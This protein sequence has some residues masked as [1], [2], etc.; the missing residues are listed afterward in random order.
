MLF[1]IDWFVTTA[2]HAPR[3][4]GLGDS[5]GSAE[6]A[7]ASCAAGLVAEPSLRRLIRDFGDAQ[8]ANPWIRSLH[9]YRSWRLRRQD[10]DL[11]I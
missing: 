8:S 4:D 7:S 2:S 6:R 9:R 1:G 3:I 10:G 5:T 11:P